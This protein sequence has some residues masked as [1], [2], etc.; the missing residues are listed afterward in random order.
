MDRRRSDGFIDDI[1]FTTLTQCETLLL[2]SM[3]RTT[4]IEDFYYYMPIEDYEEAWVHILTL[5]WELVQDDDLWECVGVLVIPTMD[6][7]LG[8]LLD[9]D[10]SGNDCGSWG[11][12][13]LSEY[14]AKLVADSCYDCAGYAFGAGAG[15]GT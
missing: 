12:I 5:V 8:E 10:G 6:W 9:S 1:D 14:D 13:N 4:L 7:M 11:E 2:M 15:A 3:T